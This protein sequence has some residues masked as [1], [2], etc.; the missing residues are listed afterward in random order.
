MPTE[1]VL[2]SDI[3]PDSELLVRAGAVD[4]PNGRLID[5]YDGQI[6][7]IIDE[8][9]N[10]VLSVYRSR[11]VVVTRESAAAIRSAPTAFN[12]WTDMTIA[13]GDPSLG[14]ALAESI[15]AAV[16]GAIKDRI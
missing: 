11:P 3:E 14:R 5:Y 1:I 12:L 4:H 2:L 15:A 8:A 13:Y 7:Q 10:V 16:G 9:G 6:R